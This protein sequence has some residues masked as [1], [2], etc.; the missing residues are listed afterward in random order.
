MHE[1]AYQGNTDV[2]R[3]LIFANCDKAWQGRKVWTA[4]GRTC[5]RDGWTPVRYIGPGTGGLV[6]RREL[7][8]RGELQRRWG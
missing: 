2:A 3:G 7:V 4:G 8:G 1:A 5:H 6:G